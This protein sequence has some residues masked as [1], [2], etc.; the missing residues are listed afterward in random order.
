MPDL[1]GRERARAEPSSSPIAL[2]EVPEAYIPLI[3]AG[4]RGVLSLLPVD[5][6]RDRLNRLQHGADRQDFH[7]VLGI[8]RVARWNLGLCFVP[9][10]THER[11]ER[12]PGSGAKRKD[13]AAPLEVPAPLA[14]AD[15]FFFLEPVGLVDRGGIPDGRPHIESPQPHTPP[16]PVRVNVEERRAPGERAASRCRA[17]LGRVA[18]EEGRPQE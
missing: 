16:F 10:V 9:L 4:A 12:R 5:L 8:A 14:A 7:V 1:T 3:D 15:R 13:V 18:R 17:A 2:E 6:Y 11:R